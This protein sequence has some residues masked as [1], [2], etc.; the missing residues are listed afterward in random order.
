MKELSSLG[1]RLWLAL[2]YEFP[3]RSYSECLALV[4]GSVMVVAALGMLA[5]EKS[6]EP[7][8][9]RVENR[10]AYYRFAPEEGIASWYG[11]GFIGRPTASGEIY[12]PNDWVAAHRTLPL[13]TRVRVTNLGNGMTVVLRITDRGPYV[14]G[15]ILDLSRRAARFLGLKRK[16]LGKVRIEVIEYPLLR[17]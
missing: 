16:G 7:G 2:Q 17:K 8:R 13:G 6:F 15:R 9:Q 12:D 14:E 4:V 1:H 10:G 11:P 3:Y 5:L